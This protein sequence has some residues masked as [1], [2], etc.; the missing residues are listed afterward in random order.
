MLIYQ[1]ED[2]RLRVEARLGN[3]TLLLTQQQMA[4]PFQTSRQNISL[5]LQNV[6]EEGELARDP[7]HKDFLLVRH[8]G[9][10]LVSHKVDHYNLDAIL[11]VGCRV[12]NALATRFR[13]WAAQRLHE[14]LVKGFVLD[15]ARLKNPEHPFDYF[16]ELLRRIQDICTS[17]RRFYQNITATICPQISA[18]ASRMRCAVSTSALRSKASANACGVSAGFCRRARCCLDAAITLIGSRSNCATKN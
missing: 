15:D 6:F 16:D 7:T 3:E 13:M 10:R 18:A 4:D 14:Y 1:T 11:S 17:E 12:K 8:E 2:G 5:H 9:R